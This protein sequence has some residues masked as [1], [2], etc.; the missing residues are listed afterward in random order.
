MTNKDHSGTESTDLSIRDKAPRLAIPLV[1]AVLIG[2][3]WIRVLLR[4]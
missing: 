1:I 2:L 4:K 3:H